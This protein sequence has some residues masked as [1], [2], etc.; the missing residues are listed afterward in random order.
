MKLSSNLD[1]R[2]PLKLPLPTSTS[3]SK[4]TPTSS[5][6]T[7]S[8]MQLT[9]SITVICHLIFFTILVTTDIQAD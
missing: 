8:L 6:K 7:L 4:L 9:M 3:I 2:V 5:I 1:F